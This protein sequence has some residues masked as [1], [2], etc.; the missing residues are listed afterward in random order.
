MDHPE[1]ATSCN[2]Q[3]G[4]R[5]ID[6]PNHAILPTDGRPLGECRLTTLK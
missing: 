1:G 2:A 5:L 3:G 6:W 4:K